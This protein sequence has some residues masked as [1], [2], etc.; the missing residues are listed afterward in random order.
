[1]GRLS[2]VVVFVLATLSLLAEG[3]L[4]QGWME[5]L[6]LAPVVLFLLKDTSDI[7][8]NVL[9]ALSSI[10]LT[11]SGVDL[12]VR[13]FIN[14]QL[15]YT[16]FNAYTR[17]LPELSIVGRWDPNLDVVR[18][19]YGDLASMSGQPS[20][21]EWRQIRFQTD[22][23]GFRN[24]TRSGKIDLLILGDSFGAGGGT[25]QDKLFSRVL[26][27]KYGLRTYNLSYPG[28]P[29][30]E[31]V[32]FA[33]ESPKLTFA[34]H[35]I[36][37]WTWYIG[38]DLADSAGE[39]FDVGQLPWNNKLE[40]WLVK[41]RTFKNRSPMNQW[42][43][44]IQSRRANHGG[45]VMVRSLPN[46]QPILFVSGHDW[47]GLQSKQAIEHHPN[48]DKNER[49]LEAMKRLVAEKGLNLVVLV[50]PTKGEVY[51]WIVEGRDPR[52]EDAEPSGFTLAVLAACG[53]VHVQCLDTKP[54][55]VEQGRRLFASSGNLLW[56]RDDSHLGEYGHATIAEFIASNIL[57]DIL[58]E[59]L[60]TT[61]P[62]YE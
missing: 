62:E 26:E 45:E 30:D 48:F 37:V 34:P 2:I 15:H 42:W 49:T 16:P 57:K 1:M 39:I 28:G 59:R 51:R 54:Y 43:Q 23:A 8:Q 12:A 3:I 32:N 19:S 44:A 27:R 35:A 60:T 33:I 36:V 46:G 5:A 38:N 22:E 13:P 18:E 58:E 17:K 31:F 24:R 61:E 10:C 4:K 52:P 47:W 14:D 56:W 25:T 9:L 40:A 41:Y 20:F 50:L 11:L 55:L 29:Y 7:L 6:L 21:R 53:R